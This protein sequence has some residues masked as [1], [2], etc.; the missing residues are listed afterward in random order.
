MENPTMLL[1]RGYS[2]SQIDHECMLLRSSLSS[3]P[4]SF[5]ITSGSCGLFPS[6]KNV[7]WLIVETNPWPPRS[8]WFS[9]WIFVFLLLFLF[10]SHETSS[11]WNVAYLDGFRSSGMHLFRFLW[12]SLSSFFGLCSL[13]VFLT[14]L[15][16]SMLDS[17]DAI[18]GSWLPLQ[19]S[20]NLTMTQS[21]MRT[22]SMLQQ[23]TLCHFMQIGF[24]I[25][26][27]LSVVI[28]QKVCQLTMSS[29][30]KLYALTLVPLS[31]ATQIVIP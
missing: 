22:C 9:S 2:L 15:A 29:W 20:S 14:G 28:P 27:W 8:I 30:T 1:Y 21:K 24:K 26:L 19:A 17:L 4:F 25:L 5:L 16:P 13:C 23:S 12:V 18:V 3:G 7:H 31:V 11:R 6:L 10:P